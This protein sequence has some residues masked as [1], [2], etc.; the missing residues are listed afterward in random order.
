[1]AE[2]RGKGQGAGAD[3]ERERW[4]GSGTLQAGWQTGGI[5][6]A[7]AAQQKQQHKCAGLPGGRLCQTALNP[8]P[9]LTEQIAGIIMGSTKLQMISWV[10]NSNKYII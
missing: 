2:S 1:M 9:G 8:E 3:G 4:A 6:S 5:T 7:E 10:R